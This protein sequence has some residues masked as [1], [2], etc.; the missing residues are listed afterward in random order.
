MFLVLRNAVSC[1][2]GSVYLPLTS[3]CGAV[4]CFVILSL[5]AGEGEPLVR[6]QTL[7]A[8]SSSSMVWLP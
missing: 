6:E 3:G 4:K 1:V 2:L 8:I 5:M 7:G